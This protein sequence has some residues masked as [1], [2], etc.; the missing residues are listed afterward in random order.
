LDLRGVERPV[1]VLVDNVATDSW[2]HAASR[3]GVQR[4][5]RGSVAREKTIEVRAAIA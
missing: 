3:L 4:A 1:D 5:T 2:M